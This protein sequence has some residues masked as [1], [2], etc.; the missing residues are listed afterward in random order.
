MD[1]LNQPV[2]VPDPSTDIWKGF[3]Y[4]TVVYLAAI[5]GVDQSLYEA[6]AAHYQATGKKSLL[7]IALKSAD[8]VIKDIGWDRLKVFPGHQVIEMGLV[9]LY[10]I[11]G[12]KKYLDEA[13]FFLDYR[14]PYGEQYNQAHQKVTDQSKAVGHSVRATPKAGFA[15]CPLMVW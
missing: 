11:T 4:N 6:A 12:E 10:R 2:V 14:G 9:K 5:L 3:G 13:R 15:I 1:K 7:G 8:L